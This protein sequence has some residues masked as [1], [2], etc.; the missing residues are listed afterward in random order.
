[1]EG[2]DEDLLP[3]CRSVGQPTGRTYGTLRLLW[4]FRIPVAAPSARCHDWLVA[5]L[6][7]QTPDHRRSVL[8]VVATFMAFQDSS[9]CCQRSASRLPHR[10]ARHTNSGKQALPQCRKILGLNPALSEI[11][12]KST[13]D[14]M[15]ELTGADFPRCPCCKKGTMV[16]VAELPKLR[17]WDSS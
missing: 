16:I 11:P 9:S 7:T 2:W 12:I 8:R 3:L 17:P 5:P 15:V 14:L 4:L 1:M 6:G 13:Q 10:A